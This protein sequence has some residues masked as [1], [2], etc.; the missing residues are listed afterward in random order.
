MEGK[1]TNVALVVSNQQRSVEF[2]TEKVGFEIKTD[3]A[4][5]AGSRYV[6]VG[7]KGQELEIMLWEVGGVT[8]PSQ[9]ELSKG[10]AP[11]K[12]PPIV[13]RVTDCRAAHRELSGRGVRFHQ[14]PFDHPWGT[15]ATF[16]D[17]DGN[18]FSMNQ[19]PAGAAWAKK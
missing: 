2:F 17:P 14:E 4:P 7:P 12:S 18:L 13:L 3:V 15:S 11:A 16:V 5:K 10:W 19:P 9:R 8:D 6:T 1:F